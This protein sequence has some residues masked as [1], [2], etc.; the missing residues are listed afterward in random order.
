MLKKLTTLSLVTIMLITSGLNFNSKPSANLNTENTSE[1]IIFLEDEDIQRSISY[2]DNNK[3][4]YSARVQEYSE[5]N[6][7]KTEKI[8]KDTLI[9]ENKESYEENTSYAVKLDSIKKDSKLK[10]KIKE[11]SQKGSTIYVYGDGISLKEFNDTLGTNNYE[12]FDS[13]KVEDYKNNKADAS[14]LGII[15]DDLYNVIGYTASNEEG[16][17]LCQ[18]QT[19]NEDN[20][21]VNE[22]VED[23][24]VLNSI[25]DDRANE[26]DKKLS[27][28]KEKSVDLLG[29]EI[30][31]IEKNIATA[32]ATLVKSATHIAQ[33]YYY[34]VGTRTFTL[35][36]IDTNW[37]LKKESNESDSTYD[38]FDIEAHTEL[39]GEDFWALSA[40]F[41]HSIPYSADAIRDWGPDDKS[42]SSSFTV[43]I[44]WGISYDFDTSADI[45]VDDVGSQSNDYGRWL[46]TP[47][48]YYSNISNGSSDVVRFSPATAWFSTGTYA[49]LTISNSITW[50]NNAA[51][52]TKPVTTQTISVGYDY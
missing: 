47:P 17:F 15:G 6:M 46:V 42:N 25:L 50:I 23:Y 21:V 51:T 14:K 1:K 27:L 45:C 28:K 3:E 20:T 29:Y 22:L 24:Q 37:I 32:A 41:K 30:P 35:G 33:Y 10:E 7:I 5:K 38:Y 34:T 48:W 8:T 52:S 43:S 4:E 2:M 49:A 40:D 16:L 13:E 26:I 11:I 19:I 12:V 39:Y 9:K 36:H 31:F 44:P 18:I